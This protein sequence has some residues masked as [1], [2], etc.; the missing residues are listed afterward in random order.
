[1]GFL[2]MKTEQIEY[3]EFEKV[4]IRVGKVLAVE[5]FPQAR[6][7]AYKL[8]VDFGPEIG[9][10]KSSAQITNGHSKEELIGKLVICVV[11][12]APKQIGPFVSEVL[13]LGFKH[14][15]GGYQAFCIED[16]GLIELGDKLS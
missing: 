7:S 15:R 10:K 6:N 16:N 14:P 4:E 1:M 8:K 2:I 13:T 9:V 5:D 3:K 12:F 11:N